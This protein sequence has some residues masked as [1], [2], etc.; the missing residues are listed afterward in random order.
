[1]IFLNIK[2]RHVR[3]DL[4]DVL[5]KSKEKTFERSLR[6]F[7]DHIWYWSTLA[8]LDDVAAVSRCLRGC[9]LPPSL[10]WFALFLYVCV[11]VFTRCVFSFSLPLRKCLL[12][13]FFLVHSKKRII[14]SIIRTIWPYNKSELCYNSFPWSSVWWWELFVIF[15]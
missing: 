3:R 15:Y 1:M 9:V 12:R 4:I 11:C 8:H 14:S 7:R 13:V 5:T 10:R 2:N 6:K